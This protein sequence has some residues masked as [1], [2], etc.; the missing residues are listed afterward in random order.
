MPRELIPKNDP[1]IEILKQCGLI[2]CTNFPVFRHIRQTT[3]TTATPLIP[4]I[5]DMG[6]WSR[7]NSIYTLITITGEIWLGGKIGELSDDLLEK[8]CPHGEGKFVY[9]LECDFIPHIFW[10]GRSR[11]PYEDFGDSCSGDPPKRLHK[12]WM[13]W[14]KNQETTAAKTIPIKENRLFRS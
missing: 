9:L 8:L 2:N 3:T 4:R 11:D 1:Q 12:E 10:L 5:E 7:T 14:K 13:E 6:K